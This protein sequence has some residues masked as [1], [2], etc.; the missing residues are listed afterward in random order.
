MKREKK[1]IR[2][3]AQ[4]EELVLSPKPNSLV[5]CLKPSKFYNMS[6]LQ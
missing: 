2:D 6:T 1:F 4:R 3:H 5:L